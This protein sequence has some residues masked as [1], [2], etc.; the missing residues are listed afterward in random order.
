MSKAQEDAKQWLD[1]NQVETEAPRVECYVSSFVEKRWTKPQVGVLKCNVSALWVNSSSLFGGLWMV[2]DH[3]GDI[4]FHSH[5]S[6]TPSLLRMKA[7]T[8]TPNFFF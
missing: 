4:H 5:D 6:F 3:E 1:I 8:H 2:R 7:E